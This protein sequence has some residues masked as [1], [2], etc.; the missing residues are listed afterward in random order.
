MREAKFIKLADDIS[1][2]ILSGEYSAGEPLKSQH[3]LVKEYGV[4]RSCVQK[5]INLLDERGAVERRPGVGVFV[6]SPAKAS[7]EV[8]SV[9]Y[10]LPEGMRTTLNAYDNYGV[11]MMLGAEE[12]VRGLD[13]GFML[14]RCDDASLD[15]LP[16]AIKSLGCSGALIS[17]NISERAE[18]LLVSSGIPTVVVG[19]LPGTP[20]AGSTVPNYYDAYFQ[21]FNLLA[22]SRAGSVGVFYHG[23][24][25]YSEDIRAACERAK[26]L[27]G[28]EICQF[29]Y[30]FGLP[31]D[32]SKAPVQMLEKLGELIASGKMPD[33]LCFTSDSSAEI[34]IEK[35]RENG[36]D[37]PG[38]IS[39]AGALGLESGR[40]FSPPLTTLSIDSAELGRRG[41]RVLRMM[42]DE[43]SENVVE[44]IPM[45]IIERE[46]LAFGL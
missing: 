17:W 18:K 19:R 11:G 30:S 28:L 22:D 9:A 36:L 14:R 16:S 4:S 2:K 43:P 6:A 31:H 33:S 15:S 45:K 40:V 24:H 23:G 37:V 38:D 29:D 21:F 5:A 1:D 20:R 10:V 7:S 25:Y 27:E 3:E 41:A 44:R 39:V 42:M 12:A 13:L 32:G 26:N 46:S 34:A 35:L 8:R